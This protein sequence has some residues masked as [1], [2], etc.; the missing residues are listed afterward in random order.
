MEGFELKQIGKV[1]SVVSEPTD[2][3][4][5]NVKS[6]IYIDADLIGALAGLEEFSHAVIVTYL[7][8]ADF[9]IDKHLLRRPRNMDSM[10]LLGV[11]SRRDKNRPNPIGIT[12][13]E[14]VEVGDDYIEVQGLD[15]V[16]GTPVLDIKPYFM[17]FDK[18]E[19]PKEPEWVNRLMKGYF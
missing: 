12:A 15:A 14:I 3:N 13:V 16:D 5:G 9:D 2:K 8:L 4:W 11:F 1:V 17:S 10:P 19:N 18:I 6:K 7:H